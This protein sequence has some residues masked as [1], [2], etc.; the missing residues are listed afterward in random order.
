MSLDARIEKGS[1]H[2]PL[3][4]LSNSVKFDSCLFK[5]NAVALMVHNCP[6]PEARRVRGGA[7]THHRRC[8]DERKLPGPFCSGLIQSF[9]TPFL[10]I[11]ARPPTSASSHPP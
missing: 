11:I 5:E 10:A 8:A 4:A 7:W 9:E 2:P 3:R 1:I 6:K